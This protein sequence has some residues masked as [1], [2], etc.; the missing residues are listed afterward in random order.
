MSVPTIIEIV[1][2]AILGMGVGIGE[3]ISRYRDA[4]ARAIRTRP[5]YLYVAL[6]ALLR[7]R[8]LR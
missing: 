3:L 4:P 5:A 1:L 7:S 6:N 2:V 8:S